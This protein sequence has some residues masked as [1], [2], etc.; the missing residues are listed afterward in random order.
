MA[1]GGA[2]HLLGGESGSLRHTSDMSDIKMM[3]FLST[4]LLAGVSGWLT[5]LFFFPQKWEKISRKE[6]DFHCRKKWFPEK[7]ARWQLAFSLGKG[8]KITLILMW[9]SLLLCLISL[10]RNFNF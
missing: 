10:W 4:A 1:Q 5:L 7:F 9:S 8:L 3:L 6:Y 2:F